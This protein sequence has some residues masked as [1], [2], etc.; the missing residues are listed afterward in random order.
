M[1]FKEALDAGLI[2]TDK[3]SYS[4]KVTG[5]VMYLGDAIR[6]GFIKVT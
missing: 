1:T 6:K 2:D 5:K 4:N 3:G